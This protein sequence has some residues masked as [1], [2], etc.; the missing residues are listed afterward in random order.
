MSCNYVDVFLLPFILQVKVGGIAEHTCGFVFLCPGQYFINVRCFEKANVDLEQSFRGRTQV[1][2]GEFLG[3]RRSRSSRTESFTDSLLLRERSYSS[4]LAKFAYAAIINVVED[5]SAEQRGAPSNTEGK[6]SSLRNESSR[7]NGGEL[8]HPEVMETCEDTNDDEVSKIVTS[9]EG[10]QLSSTIE[11]N[12]ERVN[13]MLNETVSGGIEARD[14]NLLG[15]QVM[16]SVIKSMESGATATTETD[17]IVEEKE[18]D[19]AS[20]GE[21]STESVS[22]ETNEQGDEKTKERSYEPINKP[23]RQVIPQQTYKEIN[24]Q[25]HPTSMDANPNGNDEEKIRSPSVQERIMFFNSN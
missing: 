1:I 25:T 18:R 23:T 22:K 5:P 17:I 2:K 11:R 16:T 7:G 15:E 12:E 4:P 20:N 6:H 24:E 14:P 3:N 13:E 9:S 10:K 19:V 8:G 21:D